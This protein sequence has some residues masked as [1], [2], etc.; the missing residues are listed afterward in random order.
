MP[1]GLPDDCEKVW[2]EMSI[3]GIENH[4]PSTEYDK[5]SIKQL[6]LLYRDTQLML[7]NPFNLSPE[8]INDLRTNSQKLRAELDRQITLVRRLHPK[9]FICLYIRINLV[10]IVI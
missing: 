5:E 10:I 8:Q 1:R 9:C 4:E 7:K 3:T 2:R 6:A